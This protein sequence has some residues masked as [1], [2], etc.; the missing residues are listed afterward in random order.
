MSFEGIK[1]SAG[2]EKRYKNDRFVQR[3]E[4]G[5]V[6]TS[7]FSSIWIDRV[8]GVNYLYFHDRYGSGI[9]PLIGS[10]GKI[11]VSNVDDWK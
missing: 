8:T 7:Q 2:L 4:E 3:F 11:V 6:T 1:N 5:H 9:T 10:D